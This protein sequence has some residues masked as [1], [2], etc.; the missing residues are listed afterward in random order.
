[1]LNWATATEVNN[2]GF[3][4]ERAGRKEV[5]SSEFSVLSYEKIGFVRGS[6]NSNS[7]KEYSFT[8]NTAKAGRYSYRLK[9][10]DNDG[11]FKYSNAVETHGCASLP[12]NYTLSQ[13]YPNPFNPSTVINYQLP[14]AAHVSLRIYD[15][16]GCEVASLVNEKKDAG[17]YSA[18]FN[19][20][21]LPSGVY[22]YT[23][24]AGRF[25]QSRKLML[26]K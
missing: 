10:I 20:G 13:N 15:M 3:E 7:V 18:S 21:S 2:Y 17:A 26:L 6:G 4:I 9:Q 5:M 23:L 1:V 25:S 24:Q 11:Q 19:A 22:I 8:D 14:E 16:L 12:E